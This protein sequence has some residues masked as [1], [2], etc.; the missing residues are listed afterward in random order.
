MGL[1][2]KN[3]VNSILSAD[4]ERKAAFG[5]P[6]LTT[7]EY[8][9]HISNAELKNSK[10]NND[11]YLSIE[12]SADADHNPLRETYMLAGNGREIGLQKIVTFFANAFKHEMEECED[13]KQLLSQVLRFKGKKFKAA[14][15]NQ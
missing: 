4:K 8:L 11:P 6:G 12:L 5:K 15:R 14:V 9:M 1:L 13:E 2:S 7:G 10:D 3:T